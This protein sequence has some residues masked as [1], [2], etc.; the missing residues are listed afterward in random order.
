MATIDGKNILST[1]KMALLAGSYDSLFKYPKRT[2]VKYTNYAE[3]DGINPLLSKFETEPRRVSLNFMIRHNSQS[4]FWGL[5]NNFCNEMMSDG[6]RTMN[7]ENGLTYELRYDKMQRARA[8]RMFDYSDGA[9]SFTIDFIE[10][11]TAIKPSVVN[12]VG[13][14]RLKGMF[15]VDGRDFGDFG[16]HPDGDIGEVLRLADVKDRFF[17]GREYYVA[18]SKLKHRELTLNFWMLSA[19]KSEFVHNY[20]A[21]YNA[22]AKTGK[23]SLYSKEADG[24]T[25][26]YYMDCT[27]YKVLWS[28]SPAAKF[29]IKF[30]VPVVNWS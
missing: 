8:I 13:G 23:Q 21:F 9:T 6:Y 24:T 3:V 1:W 26:V 2:T 18:D 10:D 22:F 7:L 16:I 17:D 27:S 15:V 12:P 19:S 4:E 20:Q 30:C 29:G 14:V 5:Y 28:D 25:D 11:T